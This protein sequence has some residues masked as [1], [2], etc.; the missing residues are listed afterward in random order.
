MSRDCFFVSAANRVATVSCRD[1]RRSDEDPGAFPGAGRA[2]RG[3]GHQRGAREGAR[4]A[5]H[6]ARRDVGAYHGTVLRL[7]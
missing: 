5:S 3:A 6:A 2:Q 1:G 7:S 4:G